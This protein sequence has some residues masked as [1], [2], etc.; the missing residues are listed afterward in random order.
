MLPS[1]DEKLQL[2]TYI[3]GRNILDGL[4]L[5]GGRVCREAAVQGVKKVQ[6]YAHFAKTQWYNFTKSLPDP[7]GGRDRRTYDP[8]SHAPEDCVRFLEQ[9]ARSFSYTEQGAEVPPPPPAAGKGGGAYYWGGGYWPPAPPAPPKGAV[10]ALSGW[11][12][13]GQKGGPQ[14]G[15]YGAYKGGPG[16]SYKGDYGFG[17]GGQGGGSGSSSKGGPGGA[18]KGNFNNDDW[19]CPR[20]GATNFK[21]KMSCHICWQTARPGSGSEL[22]LPEGRWLT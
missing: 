19:Y 18:G 21:K 17:G 6:N 22:G 1:D 13:D 20:C 14:V 9:M 2:R 11:H 3:A 5:P 16:G 7:S 15:G 10:L 8:S 12:G 4:Y